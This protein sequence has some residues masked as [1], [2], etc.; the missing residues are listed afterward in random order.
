M[1]KSKIRKIHL[2]LIIL[3]FFAGTFTRI[4]GLGKIPAGLTNDEANTGYDAYSILK[5]GK[6]QW[7]DTQPNVYLR[8]FGD[9]RPSLYTYALIPSVEIFD[10][11]AFS[12]RLPA[13][14]AGSLTI[15]LVFTLSLLLWDSIPV[16]II[17]MS[18]LAFNPWH[19]AMSRVGIESTFAVFL[20]VFALNLFLIGIRKRIWFYASALFFALTIYTYT[21]YIIFIPLF[22]GVL[23]FINRKK[24]LNKKALLIFLFIFFILLFPLIVRGLFKTASAR[25]HQVNL[26]QDIGIINNVNEKRG[27]CKIVFNGRLCQVF[28][29]KFSAFAFT[30]I[31]NYLNHFS[32]E[33]LVNVG[34]KTQYSVLQERGLL[35]AFEYIFFL[36]GFVFLFRKKGSVKFILLFWILLAPLPDSI[37]GSGHY[38]RYV[39]ILPALQLI[40]AIGMYETWMFFGKKKWVMLPVF[41]IALYEI[42]AFLITYWSYF[43]VFYSRYSHYGYKNLM[44]YVKTNENKYDKIIISS[45]VNDTKQYIFY[46][47]YTKYDPYLYQSGRGIEKKVEENGW[48]RVEKIGNVFFLPSIDLNL[49]YAEKPLPNI[50]LIGAPVEFV[51]TIKAE[52]QIKDLKKDVL[53]DTV[54]L[55]K[56]PKFT[57]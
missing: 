54:E 1:I 22:L 32:P 55:K 34:T 21:A 46:L 56:N 20:M 41:I 11:N 48:V 31:S 4:N 19:I 10:L 37:T 2:L 8:G 12:V 25:S 35:Y 33:L 40:G 24:F 18:L 5:T 16:A 15:I 13:A 27:E 9:Y 29:N 3:I 51:K 17:A 52:Y 38:S 6:D 36:I 45:S 30:F 50:L 47:F 53:F 7:G 23:L 39:L 44:E 49:L 42:T 43:P 28:Q 57:Y 14:I 26:T